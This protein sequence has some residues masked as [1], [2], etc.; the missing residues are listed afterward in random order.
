[1]EDETPAL[2]LKLRFEGLLHCVTVLIG[3]H[4][5]I[6]IS[7]ATKERKKNTEHPL[8]IKR[9]RQTSKVIDEAAT[10]VS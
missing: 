9:M 5:F 10:A 1:M 6:D 4:L 3:S 7:D 2:L 8:P